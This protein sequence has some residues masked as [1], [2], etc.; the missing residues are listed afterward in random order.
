[1]DSNTNDRMSIIEA[2]LDLHEAQMAV[3]RKDL[4]SLRQQLVRLIV[5]Y[6]ELDYELTKPARN[7]NTKKEDPSNI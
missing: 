5:M 7:A 1:M 6:N 4:S 3:V 2:K